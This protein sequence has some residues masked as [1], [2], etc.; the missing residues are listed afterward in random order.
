MSS[1]KNGSPPK[2]PGGATLKFEVELFGWKEKRLARHELPE[3]ELIPEAAVRK[4]KAT[5]H[6]KA[7]RYDEAADDYA[8]AASLV[9]FR[10]EPE[11]R[12]LHLTCL[13]NEATAALKNDEF[14]RAC[15][16]STKALESDASS[17]KALLRRGQARMG[18]GEFGA[19]LADLRE[20]NLQDP[21][22]KDVREAFAK[23][24]EMEKAVKKKD[25]E[26][27]AKMMGGA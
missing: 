27:Y 4:A 17:V 24:V 11:G 5:E 8:D 16:A 25:K 13:V 7:G 3:E 12:S 19:A 26:L 14:R 6:F 22:S 23:C 15:R 2:I 20:A 1:G 9:E 21:K 18:L 10:P